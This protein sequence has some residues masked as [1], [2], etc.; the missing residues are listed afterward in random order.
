MDR[1]QKVEKPKPESPINENEIRITTQ[2]AI[3]NY[4]T[5]ASSLLQEK[6]ASEIVLKAMGQAI[7]KT[8]AIAE[9]LKKRIPKLHQDTGISSVSIVD[10]WEPIEEGL[11][12]VEMTRHVSM[13]SITLSTRE[14]DENSPGYQAPSNVEQPKQHSNYQQQSIKP[15]RVPYNATH[16]VEVGVGVGVGEEVEEGIG[17]GVAMAIKVV[18]QIIKDTGITR[19]VM[20]IIK[21]MVGIQ[22]GD[23]VVGE[24]EVGG[25][26]VA[27]V[28][29][30]K[31]AEVV[32][33]KEAE[34]EG[35]MGVVGAEWV[36]G[37]GVV[38]ATRHDCKGCYCHSC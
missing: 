27:E 19:G 29:A 9:I 13:I 4:I 7:S 12:P 34:E 22:T 35:V 21:I 20:Q 2:G 18:M 25:I 26:V 3:R 15:A 31:V 36:D 33:M 24:V 17:E 28:V 16:M 1:Y 14:L 30:M 37:Q 32:V 11:V 8:V 10:T 5:Y 23:E 6:H 38:V